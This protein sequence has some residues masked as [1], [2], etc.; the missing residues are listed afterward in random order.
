MLNLAF[1]ASALELRKFHFSQEENA[2]LHRIEFFRILFKGLLFQCS[3]IAI[4]DRFFI[5]NEFK[6]ESFIDC[7]RPAWH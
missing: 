5:Q 2:I 3:R 1:M 4:S 7:S 6:K